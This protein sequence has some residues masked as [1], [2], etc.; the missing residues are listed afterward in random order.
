MRIILIRHGESV[1]N[2]EKF[3]S[4]AKTSPLTKLGIK[5]AKAAGKF[6][7][8]NYDIKKLYYLP[9]TR[10]TQTAQIINKTLKVPMEMN[11]NIREG[12]NSQMLLGITAENL[13][14]APK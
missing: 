9:L 14:T 1:A 8:D 12:D 7:K 4:D 13:E 10:A 2:T 3:L 5:Q 11:D 6:L